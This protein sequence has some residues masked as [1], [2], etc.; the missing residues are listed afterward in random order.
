MFVFN[1][2]FKSF[3]F[4]S[5]LCASLPSGIIENTSTLSPPIASAKSLN[6]FIVTPTLNFSPLF[7]SK[8]LAPHPAKETNIP[9]I[10]PKLINFFFTIPPHLCK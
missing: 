8:S 5:K 6:G 2:S 7:S 1:K 9:N 3:G 10:S 4:G